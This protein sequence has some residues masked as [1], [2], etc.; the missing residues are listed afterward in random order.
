[1]PTRPNGDTLRWLDT[2]YKEGSA[3][4]MSDAA[5]LERFL[6]RP[7]TAGEAAFEALVRRHGPMVLSLC[8]GVLRDD[9]DADDAFQA[10]FLVLARRAATVRDRDRLATWLGH[11]ARRIALRSRREAARRKIREREGTDV[12]SQTAPIATTFVAL[13]T[14]SVVRA[15]VERL[16][17]ADRLPLQLTYWQGKTYEEAAAL[18]SWPI[19]TVRSRLARARQR[20]RGTLARLSVAPVLA[21]TGLAALAEAASAQPSDALVMQTVRAAMRYAGGVSAALEI[22]AVSTSVAA[23]VDGELAMSAMIPW[24][25][26]AALLLVAG[27]VTA[28]TL[29]LA[30]RAPEAPSGGRETAPVAT[31]LAAEPATPAARLAEQ[32]KAADKALLS[33]GGVEEGAGDSP[34]TWSKGAT[35][36]GVAYIWSRDTS[37]EGEASLCL[38]KTAQ[39]YFPIAQWYQK[40]DHKGESPR[41]KVSAWV[42]AEKAAKAILDA[43]FIDG[44]GQQTHAWVAYIGAK[45]AGD[46]PVTHDWKR[47]EGVVTIPPG[48]KQIIIAPQIYGPGTVWFDDLGAEYTTDPKTDP[49]GS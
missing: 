23:L 30:R 9:H 22:G 41:L 49:L 48:T 25:L 27:T 3:T 21:A 24:K 40:V 31:G 11:V 4:G 7:G 13:E 44:D 12:G 26:G 36:A 42:K 37:H 38:K 34:K 10:T 17:A 29:S 6:A 43:Q 16:P 28:G 46:P 19:G 33:D 5:L 18:L 32:G 35:I 8:R 14:A 15:E 39:R 1:M 20:L 2:L 45:E 47:Y